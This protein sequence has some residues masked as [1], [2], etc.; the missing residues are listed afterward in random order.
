MKNFRLLKP[1]GKKLINLISFYAEYY[2]EYYTKYHTEY[3][4]KYHTEYNTDYYT[5][6][7]AIDLNT[8]YFLRLVYSMKYKYDSICI[9]L[10]I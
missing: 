7:H 2:T 9:E 4:T 1:K 3:N 6:Y 8:S 10:N 5:Q